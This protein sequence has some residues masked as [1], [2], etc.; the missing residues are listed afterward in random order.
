MAP[1]EAGKEQV[2]G[3]AL[4]LPDIAPWLAG[5]QIVREIFV[6]RRLVNF[7]VRQEA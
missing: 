5:K 7:V 6:P 3:L 4:A 2:V 1:A